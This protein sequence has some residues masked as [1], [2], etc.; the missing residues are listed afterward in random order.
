MKKEWRNIF[1]G[2]TPEEKQA[3][4]KLDA[5]WRKNKH[6]E[7]I[8][9]RLTDFQ[10]NELIPVLRQYGNGCTQNTRLVASELLLNAVFYGDGYLSL[11]VITQ[12]HLSCVYCENDSLRQPKCFQRLLSAAEIELARTLGVQRGSSTCTHKRGLSIVFGL[13]RQVE[14][15]PGKVEAMIR[16]DSDPVVKHPVITVWEEE[17]FIYRSTVICQRCWQISPD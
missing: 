11:G 3:T 6:R 12:E 8:V 7:L 2:L 15:T 10:R 17:K 5:K 14:I 16:P 13:S 1:L 9:R 4:D